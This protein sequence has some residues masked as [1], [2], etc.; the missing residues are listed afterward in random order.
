MRRFVAV[1]AL[2]LFALMLSS[3]EESSKTTAQAEGDDSGGSASANMS[4]EAPTFDDEDDNNGGFDETGGGG[5]PSD[6]EGGY[7]SGFDPSGNTGPPEGWDDDNGGYGEGFDP[8]GNSGPPEGWD[9]DNGGYGEGF[10]PSG[11]SG[12]PEGYDDD[13]NG[14]Y[15]EGFDPSGNSDEGGSGGAS[16]PGLNAP[17][18]EDDAYPGGFPGAGGPPG[19]QQ[20]TAAKPKSEGLLGKAEAAFIAGR[21]SDG[22]A[23]L[24]ALALTDEQSGMLDKVQWVSG[25]RHPALAIR[26]GVGVSLTKPKNFNK[27]YFPIGTDQNLPQIGRRGG[28]R[29]G[30]GGYGD[31]G[32]PDLGDPSAGGG[33]EPGYG[34]GGGNRG[35]GDLLSQTTGELSEQVLEGFRRRVQDGLYG[36]ILKDMADLAGT[37][38]NRG[39]G[40]GGGF[41]DGGFPYGDEGG[42]GGAAGTAGYLGAP[43]FGP[44]GAGGPPGPGPA[45][46]NRQED[47]DEDQ[48]GLVSLMPGV[49]ML[50]EGSMRELQEQAQDEGLDVLV[51]FDVDIKEI[52]RSGLVTNECRIMVYRVSDGELIARSKELNNIQVQRARAESED[53]DP[54][55]EAITKLFDGLESEEAAY[56]MSEMPEGLLPEHVIGRV[57]TLVSSQPQ[58]LLA[59]LTEIKFYHHRNLLDDNTLTQAF[60]RM[61]GELDGQQLAQ[62]TKEERMKVVEQKKWLP[63]E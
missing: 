21:D 61:V 7:E 13:P 5:P 48:G 28:D 62:G 23:Y 22:F 37:G 1:C 4:M 11:N 20:R 41:G 35:G 38:G 34:F 58:N 33:G 8:S 32:I 42:G 39:G 27:S 14:G 12:P 19:G 60:Q 46:G 43:N 55:E 25:L 40:A 63:A 50:G 24:Y 59:A 52:R 36:L 16:A 17:G 57:A 45:A 6:D 53:D 30:F 56:A 31:G 2:G 26:W 29:G 51:L 15:G 54:V 47:R 3:C 18:G 49:S 10:D 9:D 44:P